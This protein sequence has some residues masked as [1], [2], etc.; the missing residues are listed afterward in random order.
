MFS[1]LYYTYLILSIMIKE[2]KKHVGEKIVSKPE[3]VVFSDY[4][5]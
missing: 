5:N 4:N 1:F 2:K 3:F